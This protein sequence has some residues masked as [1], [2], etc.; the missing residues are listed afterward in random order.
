MAEGFPE[1]DRTGTAPGAPFASAMPPVSE[2]SAVVLEETGHAG[3]DAELA[4][5]EEL[6][7]TAT[8]THAALYE[9]VHQ[10]LRDTLTALDH[11]PGPAPGP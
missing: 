4:R 1:A 11:R 2:L 9:D 5:L 6:D 8:E 3:V 7:G 10:R